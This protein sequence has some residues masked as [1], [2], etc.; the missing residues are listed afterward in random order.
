MPCLEL[1]LLVQLKCTPQ[2]TCKKKDKRTRSGV[3][4]VIYI[5]MNYSETYYEKH[6]SSKCKINN[7]L[8]LHFRNFEGINAIPTLAK[9]AG[10]LFIFYLPVCA[11]SIYEYA[12]GVSVQDTILSKFCYCFLMLSPIANCIIL[13]FKNRVS[14]AKHLRT[15]H[16]D[17][18]QKCDK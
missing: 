6:I 3:K 12:A 4:Y 14:I 16:L 10:S 11:L 2:Y 7:F 9:N 18:N 17:K 8:L 1:H 5:L 15:L 13:G